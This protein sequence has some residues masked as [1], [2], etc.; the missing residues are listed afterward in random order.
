MAKIAELYAEFSARGLTG[1]QAQ[2]R[3]FHKS[4]DTVHA[5]F[6]AV[7]HYAKIAFVGVGAAVAY[8]VH[9]AIQFEKQMA[10]VNTMLDKSVGS[11]LPKYSVELKKMKVEFGESTATL[12][13]GLYDILSASIDPAKALDVLRVSSQ[14]AVGGMTTTA[15]AADA[16]TTILNSYKIEAGQV[17]SVSDKMFLTVKR[18]KLTY[19]ELA[20]SIGKAAATAAI[21][22]V[23]LDELLASVATLTRNGIKAD[24]AMTAIVGTLQSF[25]KPSDEGAKAA[26]ALGFELN[27]ATLKTLGLAGVFKLLNGL[28]A[29]QLATIF[30]NIR[31]L[32][33]VAASMQD[34]AGFAYDLARMI[35]ASGEAQEAFG[36]MSETTAFKLNRLKQQ[37]SALAGELGV[38]FVPIV[39]DATSLLGGLMEAVKELDPM[40]KAHLVTIAEWVLGLSAVLIILPK[41]IAGIK[42]LAAAMFVLTASNPMTL[43]IY[44]FIAAIYAFIAAIGLFLYAVYRVAD[45]YADLK[46]GVEK[47]QMNITKP[48]HRKELAA[49]AEGGQRRVSERASSISRSMTEPITAK[50]PGAA[51]TGVSTYDWRKM[52][53]KLAGGLTDAQEGIIRGRFGEKAA[54]HFKI[55]AEGK[56]NVAELRAIKTELQKAKKEGELTDYMYGELTKQAEAAFFAKSEELKVRATNLPGIFGEL[57]EAKPSGGVWKGLTD[58]WR[59]AQSAALK[60]DPQ[61]DELKKHTNYLKAIAEGTQF[62]STA[63]GGGT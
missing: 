2:M 18:G 28:Q 56:A 31:G 11:Y 48:S 19:E 20:G 36:K 14:A 62:Q 51:V 33:G 3:A 30:P 43:A 10:M 6:T 46:A 29:E 61:L 34:Q 53:E 57:G 45:A 63:V 59:D 21:S 55:T 25:L 27:T 42:A 15:V 4:L 22:G 58:V 50:T 44:A 1:L 39:R 17:E 9:S 26:H 38:A 60:Q 54:E 5:S 52:S 8:G 47:V 7:A 12:A 23:S 35:N 49:W 41:L 32:K 16:L 24:L 13:K 37:F 40:T